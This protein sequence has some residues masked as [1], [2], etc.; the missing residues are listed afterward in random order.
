[1]EGECRWPA[2]AAEYNASISNDLG[3]SMEQ[4]DRVW[5]DPLYVTTQRVPATPANCGGKLVPCLTVLWH[6][7]PRRVGG[8]FML[9]TLPAGRQVALSRLDPAFVTRDGEPPRPLGDPFLSRRP[10]L[11]RAGAR[12]EVR[13]DAGASPNRLAVGGERVAGV[14]T[15]APEA[16]AGGTVLL[17]NERVALVLHL[18]A[19]APALDLPA[20][21]LVGESGA[22]HE[23]RRQIRQAGGVASPVLLR[24]ETGTGKELAARAV[25]ATGP[26]PE[27]PYL[28]LNMAA[29]PPS[30]AAAELFGAARGSFTG[31]VQRQSGYFARA[32]GGTLLLDEIGE[33]PPEVQ[34][35][36]LRALETGE[37]QPVGGG[38]PQTVDVRVIAAT[39][40]DLEALVA[41]GTFRAPLLHRLAGCEIV[42]PPLRRRREDVGL[43]LLHFLGE[44]LRAVGREDLLRR[45]PAG[46][47]P[48]LAAPLVA[49]LAACEWPGNV[50]Q[51]RGVVR[52][53]VAAH[54]DDDEA[55]ATPQIER[56][57]AGV[58]TASPASP[59]GEGR[60]ARRAYRKPAEVDEA[61][62]VAT[63]RAHAFEVKAA[64]RTLGVS[65]AALYLLIERCPRLR[66]AADL[67][68]G[69]IERALDGAGGE[70]DGAAAALEVSREGL[71]QRLHA[72]GAESRR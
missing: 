72:L 37:I 19:A 61:E 8:R 57:L 62:L 15:L 40:A 18:A 44:E 63:L 66:K 11:L 9:R 47:P 31:A 71:R 6:P 54:R 20:L 30:L 36:L 52:Q 35:L 70:L 34:S 45:R 48:W 58:P 68:R 64:A 22:M 7:D 27:G 55:R 3:V 2:T 25:H 12:G 5:R 53:L 38:R 60:A 39:D 24:G 21:G 13:L 46:E 23:V 16:V 10:I 41:A 4:D 33:T 26:R 56:L 17:L 14:L 65:R 59:A 43:L 69:E 67:D 28:A 29:V 1:V 51:L 50:R 42:L 32:D 49:R